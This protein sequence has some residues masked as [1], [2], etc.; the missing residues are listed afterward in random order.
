MKIGGNYRVRDIGAHQWRAQ[1][2]SMAVAQEQLYAQLR[3]LLSDVPDATRDELEA[4]K[5]AG[6]KLDAL[7]R[8]ARAL[9]QRVERT[10]REM[11]FLF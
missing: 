1:A 9:R 6:L 2:K 10:K 7:T 3:Q 8:L 11:A 4:C 5:S